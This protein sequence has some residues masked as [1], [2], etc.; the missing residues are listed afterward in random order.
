[1]SHLTTYNSKVLVNCKKTLLTKAVKDLGLTIDYNIKQIK[2]TWITE[3]VDAGFLKDGKPISVGIKFVK[4][5]NNTILEVAGDFFCTGLNE[6]T[7]IDKLSQSYKKYDIIFQCEQ[8]GWTV[9]RE[10]ISIDSKTNE[11][12]IQASRY[13]A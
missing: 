13:V 8:Q 7:F 2:N 10:D 3:N 4:D 1:M 5:R 12:V 6:S 9:N 11:I